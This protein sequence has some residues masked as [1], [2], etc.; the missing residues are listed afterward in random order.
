MSRRC[1]LHIKEYNYTCKGFSIIKSESS[2]RKFVTRKEKF[3]LCYKIMIMEDAVTYM[4]EALG[5]LYSK[6]EL[7]SMIRLIMERVCGVPAYQLL[8][9][10]ER[11]PTESEGKKIQDIVCRLK[12]AEPLQ[13][14]IGITDFYS[15]EFEVNPSV[16]I[17]RPETEELVDMIIHDHDG[18]EGSILDVGTGSGCIAITLSKHLPKANVIGIDVSSEAL[19]VA[20]KNARRN[21][22]KVSFKQVDI[23]STEQIEHSSLI[24]FDLIVS[25]P[26]Y[27]ME[28][29]KMNMERNVLDYEPALALFVPDNNSLLFYKAIANLGKIYLKPGGQLYFEI[30]PLCGA[31]CAAMLHDVGYM[32]IRRL[33]DMSGN[34]R[35]IKANL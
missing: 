5:D 26:P 29:E 25:N 35:F 1:L 32:D 12:K 30:N 28:Q 15:M 23:L 7:S 16:L 10:I 3:Y 24:K 27:I 14:I 20:D 18:M 19:V 34:E 11:K 21:G 31:E 33:L 17:P 9:K 4:K 22:V 13:Y 2:E 6:R 8:A